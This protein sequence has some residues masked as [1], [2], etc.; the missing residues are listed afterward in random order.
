MYIDIGTYTI[1]CSRAPYAYLCINIFLE[2]S[3]HICVLGLSS[4]RVSKIFLLDSGIFKTVVF[5]SFYFI[6][7]A[8]LQLA[9]DSWEVKFR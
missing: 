2:I 1:Q 7:N 5:V 6:S 9:L 4:L 8:G 3:S